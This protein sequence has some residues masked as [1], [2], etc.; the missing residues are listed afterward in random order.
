MLCTKK[1]VDLVIKWMVAQ[2]ESVRKGKSSGNDKRKGKRRGEKW[3]E[4][5]ERLFAFV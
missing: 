5:K 1:D 4:G 3:F 2:Q